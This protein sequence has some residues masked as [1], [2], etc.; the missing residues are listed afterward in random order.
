MNLP[1]FGRMVSRGGATLALA[2]TLA[3]CAACGGGGGTEGTASPDAG[4]TPAVSGEVQV[5]EE[6]AV[7]E[8]ETPVAEATPERRAPQV[9]SV[10]R[11]RD[12]FV[13]PTVSA[14]EA[15]P[16]VP[17]TTPTTA[18]PGS[19]AASTQGAASVPGQIPGQVKAPTKPVMPQPDVVV[20][21]VVRSARGNRAILRGPEGPEIVV[22]GQKLGEFVVSAID[23]KGVTLSWKGHRVQV[24]FEREVF[25]LKSPPV[26]KDKDDQRQPRTRR[27]EPQGRR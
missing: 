12:P 10:G 22:V 27:P 13:N 24:P 7:A 14:V 23:V 26:P 4:A 6:E 11:V 19:G 2:G 8:A 3:L 25:S 18:A 21:G 15:P 1:L 5:T 9:R 20:T 17:S 16:Q